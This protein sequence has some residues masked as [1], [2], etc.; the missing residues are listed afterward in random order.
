[1]EKKIPQELRQ[2]VYERGKEKHP[3]KC[4]GTWTWIPGTLKVWCQGC[5]YT[6]SISL[7]T[8]ELRHLPI[9]E[10]TER[11]I[12]IEEYGRKGYEG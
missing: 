6:M 5:G 1:M 4:Y 7:L 8:K 3:N 2:R 12:E 11:C 9:I 10:A